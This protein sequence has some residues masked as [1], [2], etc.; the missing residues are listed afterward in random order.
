MQPTDA[1]QDVLFTALSTIFIRK[2]EL[3]H[4]LGL[5]QKLLDNLKCATISSEVIPTC[6]KAMSVLLKHLA[7]TDGMRITALFVTSALQKVSHEN[8]ADALQDQNDGFVIGSLVLD[9]FTDYLCV[10]SPV[11]GTER[12]AK[13]I[14]NKVGSFFSILFS[15]PSSLLLL[16]LLLLQ[17]PP[18]I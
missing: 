8:T 12:F 5:L 3:I 16:S 14:T 17:S 1:F 4:G 10:A 15:L 9:A 18:L 6:K 13:T 2:I 7:T 11:D